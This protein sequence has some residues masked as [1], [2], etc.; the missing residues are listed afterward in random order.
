[1]ET[2]DKWVFGLLGVILLSLSF[3]FGFFVGIEYQ[4]R[5]VA[6][7]IRT[8]HLDKIGIGIRRQ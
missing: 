5:K 8:F 1:M 2:K 6:E 3:A 4:K 7:A